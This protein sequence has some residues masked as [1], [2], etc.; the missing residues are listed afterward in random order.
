MARFALT[1]GF[2]MQPL[3]CYSLLVLDPIMRRRR[4]FL[5]GSFS[6]V[7]CCEYVDNFTQNRDRT[8][9]RERVSRPKA[10]VEPAN[11]LVLETVPKLGTTPAIGTTRTVAWDA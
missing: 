2:G 10:G 7:N 9:W 11:P 4:N 3:V 6:F 8:L 5:F 1:L